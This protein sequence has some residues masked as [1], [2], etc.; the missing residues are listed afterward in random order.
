M[1]ANAMYQTCT[2]MLWA[3]LQAWA[4][5]LAFLAFVCL[6]GSIAHAAKPPAG[7]TI[8]AQ[9]IATYSPAGGLGPENV[10]SNIVIAVVQPVE[11]LTLIQNNN[12][13]RPVGSIVTFSHLLSNVGNVT[14]SYTL[15]LDASGCPIP[16]TGFT[17][18]S[19]Y[20]DVNSNGV[21]DS[22]DRKLNLNAKAALTLAPDTNVSLLLQ[23]Q[24][25]TAQLGSKSCMRLVATTDGLGNQASNIDTVTLS[26]NAAVVL[27]KAVAYTDVP[28]SGTVLTY[29]ITGNNIG[30]ANA[31]PASGS[32]VPT[33]TPVLVN[34]VAQ[35]LFLLRDP[36]PTDGLRY[37]AGS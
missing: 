20:V 25:P 27:N 29:T 16:N 23:G 28:K 18:S 36:L 30:D 12:L 9:A 21:I 3:R 19:F 7:T 13:L 5:A 8:T 26:S 17:N 24:A 4:L 6:S 33:T 32:P 22:A 1:M 14:N 34:G 2:R 31:Q 37:L 15:S 11:A 10:S 35:S